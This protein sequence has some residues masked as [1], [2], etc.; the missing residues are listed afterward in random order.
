ME[1]L[2][3][4]KNFS[5]LRKEDILLVGGKGA[6]L[7]ELTRIGMPVPPGF[8]ITTDEFKYFIEENTL[9]TKIN[10]EL[11]KISKPETVWSVKK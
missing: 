11:E 2:K 10:S 9:Q 8:S 7:G 3:F 1:E 4:I 6:N 5:E